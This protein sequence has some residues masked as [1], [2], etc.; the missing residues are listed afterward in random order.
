MQAAD[1]LREGQCVCDRNERDG[2]PGERHVQAGC[3]AARVHR[4]VDALL[5]RLVGRD[6]GHVEHVAHVEAVARDLDARE[7]VD[8]EVAERMRLRRDRREQRSEQQAEHD[9]LHEEAPFRATGA[10]RTEKWGLSARARRY[11]VA[12]PARSPRQA[13]IQPRWKNFRASCVP[14][15]SE[16]FE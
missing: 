3:K 7:A 13:A 14:S 11:H 5:S 10:Q 2:P 1:A 15:R 4:R 12:A 6:L 9:L 16:R 8:R